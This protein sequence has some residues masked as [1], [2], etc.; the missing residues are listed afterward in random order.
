MDRR[1]EVLNEAIAKE[2]ERNVRRREEVGNTG[3]EL[4]APQDLKDVPIPL[5]SDPRKRC[6]MKAAA[7]VA[8]SGRRV[9]NGCRS[10]MRPR[11]WTW[12]TCCCAKRSAHKACRRSD[13]SSPNRKPRLCTVSDLDGLTRDVLAVS[14]MMHAILI[15]VF[16]KTALCREPSASTGSLASDLFKGKGCSP[17]RA[18][19]SQ[20]CLHQHHCK[21][22]RSTLT[23]LVYSCVICRKGCQRCWLTRIDT[24]ATDHDL[25]S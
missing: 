7:A 20:H 13:P 24:I 14:H 17:G 19:V 2:V 1:G 18:V 16:V 3:G 6:A 9:K 10:G 15:L 4:A 23:P 12:T 11:C 25:E 21:F 22:L 5:G 8:S